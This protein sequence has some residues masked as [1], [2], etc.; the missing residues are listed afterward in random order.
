V[1]RFRA[2]DK[3]G[4]ARAADVLGVAS[5]AKRLAGSEMKK[6]GFPSQD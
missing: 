1:G 4:V 5:R 2:L 3:A 6:L